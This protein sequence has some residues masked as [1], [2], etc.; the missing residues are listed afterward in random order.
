MRRSFHDKSAV[1]STIAEADLSPVKEWFPTT[2]TGDGLPKDPGVYRFRIPMEHTP[3]ES[4]EFLALLR[5]RRHGVKNILFPTFE[6][7]VDDEF[8]TIPEGTEWSHRE[9][10]DPDF[11]LPDAFP[12]VQPVSDI[13]HACPFCKKMPQIKGR[14]IDLISGDKFSTALPYRF[15]Q[16][17]FVCCEWIAPA[18]RKT[19]TQLINDWDHYQQSHR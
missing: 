5:W 18:S 4:I 11:L 16:F 19:M 14:K 8:I 17:W 7:F 2:P 1:V 12:V 10:G 9:P 13:V 15:N 6:Y 3:D